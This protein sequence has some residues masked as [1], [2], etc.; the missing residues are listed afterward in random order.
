MHFNYT[1]KSGKNK[2]GITLTISLHP[3]LH[4]VPKKGRFAVPGT[5]AF[6]PRAGRPTKGGPFG[7]TLGGPIVHW[8]AQ[9]EHTHPHKINESTIQHGNE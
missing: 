2:S 8:R 7:P 5:G 4:G 3:R 1:P 9:L 6:G